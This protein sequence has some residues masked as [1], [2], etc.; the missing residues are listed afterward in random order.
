MCSKLSFYFNVNSPTFIS[1][2]DIIQANPYIGNW[3]YTA[4]LYDNSNIKIGAS[5]VNCYVQEDSDGK[6]L[7]RHFFTF[8]INGKGSISWQYTAINE[9]PDPYFQTGFTAKARITSGTGD[10]VNS[11]GCLKLTPKSDGQS[12]VVIS[13]KS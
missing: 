7:V 3:L 2:E 10:Y 13:Y 11:N 4:P 9:N 12:D 6:Y 1:K 8:F 5:S